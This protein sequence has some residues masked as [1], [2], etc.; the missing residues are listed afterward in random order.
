MYTEN[1][2][3]NLVT[4]SCFILNAVG[5]KIVTVFNQNKVFY[6]C[7]STID[8]TVQ[9]TVDSKVQYKKENLL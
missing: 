2:I 1:Y 7:I 9:D 4:L 5:N 3:L 6:D 8:F